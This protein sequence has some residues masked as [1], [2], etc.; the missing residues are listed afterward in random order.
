[1][2]YNRIQIDSIG[3]GINDITNLDLTLDNI[4]KT[5]LV[6]GDVGPIN[7][8]TLNNI[9]NLIVSETAVGV[10][11]TRSNL[12]LNN[13]SSFVVSGNILCSGSIHA[14]NI[15]LDNNISLA[16]NVQTFNQILNRLSSHLL[17]YNVKN[18]L[19]NNIYTTHNVII[20]NEINANS[21][22]NA[23]K[24]SR[25]A[26]NN[27]SNIQ[28]TIQ[29]NDVTNDNEPTNI[30]MGII[31]NVDNSPAH[32]LTSPNMPL[33]F[34]I[35][36]SKADINLLYPN[37]R[38]IPD[39]TNNQYPSLALDINGSVIINKDVIPGKITYNKYYFDTFLEI[40]PV[41]EYPKLYVNG[42]IY[43][44]NIVMFDYITKQNVNLD[45]IYMRQGNAGGLVIQ[46]NQILGGNFNKTEFTFNSNVNIGTNDNNYKLQ[47][48][49]NSEITNSLNVNNILTAT[50]SIVNN[51]FT[52]NDNGGY[53]KFYNDC[54][55][56]KS[57]FL[58]ILI[59]LN[60]FLQKL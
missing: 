38:E 14:E 17:F 8:N 42:A 9:H 53:S 46:P 4:Y 21:N 32:I 40:K 60:M 33:H 56:Y 51:N 18:Y 36:K 35:S 3:I 11:T 58:I 10:N 52:V 31:G 43:A 5:Y 23:F 45:S 54:Y 22:S 59:V 50:S 48:Y 47:I 12:I 1:M 19:E 15:I 30:S 13:S 49:G 7:T 16:S 6:I 2:D 41:T 25:Q 34:N 37:Y 28:F 55:F 26:N 24:I 57:S 44:D 20:G 39:Y 27:A 29:N